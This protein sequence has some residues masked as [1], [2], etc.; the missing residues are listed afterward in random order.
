M[1]SEAPGHNEIS[2]T[3]GGGRAHF[4][5]ES[6]PYLEE[7]TVNLILTIIEAKKEVGLTN[8]VIYSFDTVIT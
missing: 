8:Y 4:S 1:E 6:P 5:S 3:Y 2:I 7:K